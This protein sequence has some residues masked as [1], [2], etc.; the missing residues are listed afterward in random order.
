MFGVLGNVESKPNSHLRSKLDVW[1]CT[2][3]SPWD[4]KDLVDVVEGAGHSKF[5]FW[6]SKLSLLRLYRDASESRVCDLFLARNLRRSFCCFSK[7]M[8]RFAL[9]CCQKMFA[10]RRDFLSQHH[11]SFKV[12]LDILIIRLWDCEEPGKYVLLKLHGTLWLGFS[13]NELGR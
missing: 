1:S 4:G 13:L 6:G 8:S 3:V 9:R 2:V 5:C 7:E 12:V 10:N 11:S